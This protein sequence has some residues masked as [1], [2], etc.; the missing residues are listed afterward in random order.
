MTAPFDNYYVTLPLGWQLTKLSREYLDLFAGTPQ[1]CIKNARKSTPPAERVELPEPLLSMN[2]TDCVVQQ[3]MEDL[4]P[5]TAAPLTG[6]T[7]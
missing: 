1:H 7:R 2:T 4:A 3:V 6:S 5:R